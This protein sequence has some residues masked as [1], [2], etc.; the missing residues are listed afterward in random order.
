MSGQVLAGNSGA[1]QSNVRPS[2]KAS[3]RQRSRGS[4]KHEYSSKGE[5]RR[6]ADADADADV[7]GWRGFRSKDMCVMAS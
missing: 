7:V 4:P 5:R 1:W 2:E 6:K 3:N